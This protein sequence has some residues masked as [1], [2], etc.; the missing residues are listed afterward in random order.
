MKKFLSKLFA[1]F[2]LFY[3]INGASSASSL[4]HAANR[5]LVGI[6]LGIVY[7]IFSNITVF[8]INYNNPQKIFPKIIKE[9]NT[10]KLDKLIAKN[11]INAY[12][13]DKTPL[14][15]AVEA[16]NA[17]IVK[18]FIEKGAD[19]NLKGRGC[20]KVEAKPKQINHCFS[21]LHIAKING[22]PEIIDLLI[23]NGAKE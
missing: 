14:L 15:Y 7:I 9:E 1:V 12:C 13:A 4:P 17:K 21:P 11:G 10:K 18:Y 2:T 6:L 16:N 23:A 3:F 20:L 19:V 5:L 8:I 22:N